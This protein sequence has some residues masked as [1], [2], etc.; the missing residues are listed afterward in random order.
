[1]SAL[2]CE[3]RDGARLLLFQS[4]SVRPRGAWLERRT[5]AKRVILWRGTAVGAALT[6]RH[7]YVTAGADGTRLLTVDLRSRAVRT[8]GRIPPPYGPLVADRTGMQIAGMASPDGSRRQIVRIRVSPFSVSTRPLATEGE[9]AWLGDGRLASFPLGGR[10]A[11]LYT[12]TLDISSSFAW[13]AYRSAIVGTA[14]WGVGVGGQLHRAVL[15]SGPERVVRRLP[16]PTVF[17]LTA[18]R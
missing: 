9:V 17:V 8:L 11:R 6:E 7:A 13:T 14:A 18:V 5:G 16:G 2:R 1:L 4:S 3:T 15:P 12:P 10:R